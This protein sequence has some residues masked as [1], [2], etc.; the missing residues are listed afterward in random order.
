M[1]PDEIRSCNGLPIEREQCAQTAELASAL[2]RLA[3]IAEQWYA[4]VYPEKK[5]VRDAD[6]THLPTEEE[7]LRTQLGQTDEP[8]EEWVGTRERKIIDTGD[9]APNRD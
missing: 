5:P 8:I 6:I 2:A 4:K 1:T 3:T 7:K 9:T